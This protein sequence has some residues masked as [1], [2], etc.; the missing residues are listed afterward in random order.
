MSFYM[1]PREGSSFHLGIGV[2]SFQRILKD[3]NCDSF[4]Y[5]PIQTQDDYH[6]NLKQVKRIIR[7]REL[8]CHQLD[9]DDISITSAHIIFCEYAN[10][11]AADARAYLDKAIKEADELKLTGKARLR[12]LQRKSDKYRAYFC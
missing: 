12:F 9:Q 4:L 11:L 1:V 3:I 6:L 7:K 10:L 2:R 8:I 5:K